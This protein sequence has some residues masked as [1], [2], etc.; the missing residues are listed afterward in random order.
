[1]SGPAGDRESA[2][3]ASAGPAAGPTVRWRRVLISRWALVSLAAFLYWTAS[4]SLRPFVVVRLDELGAST[5]EIG[6]VAAAY[7]FF[8]LFLAIPGGR[9]VD[10]LGSSRVL[11]VSLALMVA[12][13]VAYAFAETV[14][15]LFLLQIAN[16]IVELFV[17]LTVQTLVTG[18][19]RG[20]GLAK[21]LSLF[22]FMWGLGIAIGPT[23]GGFV[24]D[25]F[26][27]P[28]LAFLY[29]GL[30]LGML[31]AIW[32][33]PERP[34]GLKT[35]GGGLGR[36]AW[37]T[38]REPAIRSVLLASFTVMYVI[39]IKST[40]YPLALQE[41]GVPVP[42]IGV[43]LSIMGI[44]SLAIRPVLPALT[45]RFGPGTVMVAG[46]V[47]G[48]VG[49]SLTPW[50][51]HIAL[52]VVFAA[53]TGAGYG[54]NPPVGMQ[55]LSEYSAD[56]N[57]GLVMGLRAAASRLAQVVQPLAFG[58]LAAVA[59]TAAAFPISGGALLALALW[60]R[61]DLVALRSNPST[62]D[63]AP[64]RGPS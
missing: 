36:D 55:L 42:L 57:R 13:G 63:P 3:P 49:I 59:G 54:S 56:T 7:A 58:S 14:L 50:L 4:H 2:E 12:L 45:R 61:R 20:D 34:A 27:F 22:S 28:T 31:L 44:A 52:L 46:T 40:F 32:V 43:L 25:S 1:V 51:F 33:A 8:A 16:G 24:Y 37:Q 48:V 26:G 18:A 35:R 53:I 17:W 10:R 38:G 62:A 30:A 15:S 39:S 11:Y 60:S 47:V 64:T 21:H 6:L 5:Q 41:Q 19:G 23:V 9:A 29:A